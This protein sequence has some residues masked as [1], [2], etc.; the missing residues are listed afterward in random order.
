M[1]PEAKNL[2]NSRTKSEVKIISF[3]SGRKIEVEMNFNQTSGHHLSLFL[4]ETWSRD[5]STP[6]GLTTTAA[7]TTAT[8]TE[9]TTF[10][11][12]TTP[13]RPWT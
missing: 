9:S 6:F 5:Y 8:T 1:K 10:P 4:N 12:T 2:L 13:G 3:Q 7:A 11:V